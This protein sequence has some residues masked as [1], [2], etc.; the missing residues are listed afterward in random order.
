MEE[1]RL[2]TNQEILKYTLS[3]NLK[4]F[5]AANNLSL[6]DLSDSTGLSASYLN[7]IE[8]GKKYPKID[9]LIPLAEKFKVN[10]NQLISPT[11]EPGAVF[12]L[13][14]LK[15]KSFKDFPFEIFGLTKLDFFELMSSNPEKFAS[16]LKAVTGMANNFEV[17]MEDFHKIAL[18]SYQEANKNFFP[19]IEEKAD[20][21][22]ENSALKTFAILDFEKILTNK[23]GYEINYS[24]L[25][26]NENLK[27][28]SSVFKT[29]KRKLLLINEN[30][31]PT[32]KLFILG[33]EI[34][35]CELGL[36]RQEENNSY[37]E[38]ILNEFKTSYFSG[39]LLIPKKLIVEDLK[40]LFQKKKFPANDFIKLMKKYNTNTEVLLNRITQVLSGYFKIENLFFIRLKSYQNP[41]SKERKLTIN[42]ELHFSKLHFA[43]GIGL[44][45]HYCRRW[46]TVTI[47]EELEKISDLK[48]KPLIRGQRSIMAN[49]GEKYFC[50]SIARE[51]SLKKKTYSCITIGIP[52]D[53]NS[54]KK[55]KFFSDLSIP[56]KVVGRT[57]ER[58]D[59]SDC[60]ERAHPPTIVNEIRKKES[61]Q[62]AIDSLI[63]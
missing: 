17:E 21:F 27:E 22:I 4:R 11:D 7:E 3:L 15:S 59:V 23:F 36:R 5:R 33:K 29:G 46:V 32:Q 51:S 48:N 38:Y 2:E 45:E 37:F 40:V 57:C 55:I 26:K 39:C 44:P 20:K 10:I 24:L 25:T 43:H 60:K 31:H 42:K 63:I 1:W 62:K 50:V 35:Y 16:L 61:I 14:F 13:T 53:Q 8:K 9:K 19:D 18:R 58:C 56:E 52:I 41:Q 34:G 54:E 6:K 28:V 12:L 49:N 47:L 30:L